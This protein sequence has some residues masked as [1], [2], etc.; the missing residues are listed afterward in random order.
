MSTQQ[1]NEKIIWVRGNTQQLLIPLEKEVVSPSGDIT[2]VDFYPDEEAVIKVILYNDYRKYEYT[3]SL[4]GNLLTITDS[5][6]L[7]VGCYG[8]AVTV[9]NPDGTRLHSNWN[10]QVVVTATNNSVL[11]EWD[12]FKQ[13][14]VKARA[15]IFFFAKGDPGTTD[16]NELINKPFIPTALVDLTDDESHRTVSD[17]EK[18]TWNNKAN[19]V[20]GKVQAIN[21]VEVTGDS[22]SVSGL[23]L[24]FT[25]LS[26]NI[27]ELLSVIGRNSDNVILIGHVKAPDLVFAFNNTA[28]RMTTLAAQGSLAETAYQKPQSGIPASDIA[29]GVIPDVSQFI[30]R[31]VN[32]LVNYY[33]KSETYTQSEVNALIGSIQKFHFEIYPSLQDITTPATNVLYLIGPTGSGSDKYEE[34]VYVNSTPKKIGDT[35]IDL[36]NYITTQALNSALQLFAQD[37][38]TELNNYALKSQIKTVN[39]N[40]LIGNGD[41]NIHPEIVNL[42]DG[43][44]SSGYYE[45]LMRTVGV[46]KLDTP[47]IFIYTAYNNN[48]IATSAM[49]FSTCT[50]TETPTTNAVIKQTLFLGTYKSIRTLS[51]TVSDNK[52]QVVDI[53][54]QIIDVKQS[55]LNA[56]V[57]KSGDSMTGDLDLNSHALLVRKPNGQNRY[58][59]RFAGTGTREGVYVGNPNMRLILEADSTLDLLHKKGNEYLTILDTENVKTVNGNSIYG[60]G[61]IDTKESFEVTYNVTP[62]ADILAAYNA[63]KKIYCNYGG[64]QFF[65]TIAESSSF[66]FQ[67]GFHDY[68]LEMSSFYVSST[69][70][71]SAINYQFLSQAISDLGTIRSGAAKG[72]TAYQKPSGGIP[73]SDLTSELQQ[74]I[75]NVPSI[76]QSIS[77][78]S[79][80]VPEQASSSNQLADKNFVNS[81]V[82]TNTA[83]YISNSGEPFTSLAQLEAYSGT[84]TNNDYAFVVGTDATGNTTYTRYKYNASQQQWSEEYVLNNSSF[85][86][87]Q[88]ASINSGIVDSDVTK[89]NALPTKP[90]LDALF[91]AKQDALV[92]GTNIKTINN[93]SVLG[94]GNLDVKDVFIAE[95]GVTTYQQVLDAYN[96]GK[97]IVV[98][99]NNGETWYKLDNYLPTVFRFSR[100]SYASTA[101][102]FCALTSSNGWGGISRTAEDT[103]NKAADFTTLNDTKYPTTKAVAD[104]VDNIVGNINSILETI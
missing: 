94:S 59:I 27:T 81:S 47:Q 42:T 41:V 18:T 84:L 71:Y 4:D 99:R 7:A 28:V 87:A 11:K 68:N 82:A 33:K 56:K 39:G 2:T 75:D 53:W 31:S 26:T 46:L 57:S 22:A 91:A 52:Y 23:F 60:S 103:S 72:A 80:L 79:D 67:S 65:M 49:C 6:T 29:N 85:T 8:V 35:S 69:T 100:H 74:T 76:L 48:H 92:S 97:I 13:Q 54:A 5:G 86:A 24:P 66:Y 55:D 10:H 64:I 98:S 43:E 38:Q 73:E 1:D 93:Q 62:Y 61:D 25:D 40:S 19:V 83:N 102:Q 50:N 17:T 58:G 12:E 45:D 34:Y 89:L 77:A 32:D 96:A 101:I 15:A 16:Y 9:K 14:D 3:P 44:H 30:T 104:Y 70:G 20:D 78:I 95:Y 88:W 37:F 36:S 21:G 63:G 90:E 51:N